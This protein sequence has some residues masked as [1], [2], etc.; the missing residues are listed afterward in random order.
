MN[1]TESSLL[2]S[3]FETAVGTAGIVW[4]NYGI[5]G[6]VLAR[7]NLGET[8]T[9]TL[10]WIMGQFPEA[11]ETDMPGEIKMLTRRVARH[12]RGETQDF[13][14][15]RMDSQDVPPFAI[16]LQTQLNCVAKVTS[17]VCNV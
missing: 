10:D 5:R 9:H 4:S 8:H 12:L 1:N 7:T 15:V 6:I 11:R 13:S 14:N 2:F 17:H 3:V 16:Q